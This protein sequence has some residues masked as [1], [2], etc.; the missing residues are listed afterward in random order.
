MVP[1]AMP[2]LILQNESQLVIEMPECAVETTGGSPIISYNLQY[3]QG[4]QILEY[5][6]IIGEAPD[7][8]ERVITR[9]GLTTDLVYKFKY[10]VRNK[11]GWSEGFSP[12]LAERTATIPDQ[13]TG[14]EFQI[15]NLL[16]VRFS[17]DAPYHGG[18][19]VTSYTILFLNHDQDTYSYI[20]AY[21]DGMQQQI[22]LQRY[23]DIPFKV[24]REAPL[25]LEY[26]D[27]VMAKV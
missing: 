9:G 1:D 4:E 21:C 5:I 22:V 20:N 15:Y 2:V 25:Y 12:E 10:R 16:N 27:V 24:L 14:L 26:N 23:C 6:S 18:S 13:V 17:W 19:P 3:D 11:Y 7:N 8:L